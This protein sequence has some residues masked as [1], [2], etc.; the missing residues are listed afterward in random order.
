MIFSHNTV[1]AAFLD[2]VFKLS[3][4]VKRVVDICMSIYTA[5]M[6]YVLYIEHVYV[7]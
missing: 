1:G 4:N 7:M 5:S 2:K 3:R 6:C